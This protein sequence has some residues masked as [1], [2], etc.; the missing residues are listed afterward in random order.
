MWS[1][2]YVVNDG[3]VEYA[4]GADPKSPPRNALWFEKG[5]RTMQPWE[6]LEFSRLR[7]SSNGDY[8]RQR[9]QQQLLKSMAKKASSAGILTNPS[10]VANIMSAA[11]NSLKM[12]THG[13]E[14]DD[15]IFGLKGLASADLIPIKT[16]G[17]TFATA[18]GGGGEGIS[19]DT[20]AMFEATADDK[21]PE[22]LAGHPEMLIN[23]GEAASGS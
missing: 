18:E 9:H 17:G 21:L 11:G 2:H 3:K 6:A 19:A 15:F 7:H 16:N 12:D 23:D 4:E 20:R 1:S 14:V 22:F 5:C 8:D 10:K 13:V